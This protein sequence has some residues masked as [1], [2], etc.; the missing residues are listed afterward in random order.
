MW[1]CIASFCDQ[2]KHNMS[3]SIV[4]MHSLSN[5][6]IIKNKQCGFYQRW[7]VTLQNKA[8]TNCLKRLD[9]LICKPLMKKPS[10]LIKNKG[11]SKIFV[12]FWNLI[13]VQGVSLYFLNV[14]EGV[15]SKKKYG[16]NSPS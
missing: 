3:C 11:N 9:T 6:E 5:Q 7:K 8:S 14:I 4:I 16:W 13:S 10:K 12:T 2:N 1:I 15:S